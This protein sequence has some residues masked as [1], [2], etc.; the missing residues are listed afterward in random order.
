[1]TI[2]SYDNYSKYFCRIEDGGVKN[3]P[4]LGVRYIYMPC[5]RGQIL[6]EKLVRGTLAKGLVMSIIWFLIAYVRPKTK[7][8]VDVEE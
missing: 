5:S 8:G 1:M 6:S 3:D 4:T 7:V 2:T